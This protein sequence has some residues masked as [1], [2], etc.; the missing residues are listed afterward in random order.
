MDTATMPAPAATAYVPAT[1]ID[2]VIA[3]LEAVSGYCKKNNSRAGYF[4]ML[5][6]CVTCRVKQG[7]LNNE[8]ENGPRME[9]LD[10]L[11]ANR[12]L[13]AWH[14]WRTGGRPTASWALAFKA[15]T[16]V[17]GI[18]LQHLL[19]GINAHINLDLGVATVETMS[20]QPLDG[21]Q[22]DFNAINA[23]LAAMIGTTKAC[24]TKI[25]PLMYLLKLQKGNLDDLL[26]QFS[27]DEARK[28]AWAFAVSLSEK[29][30]TAYDECIAARDSKIA[31]L[32]NNIAYPDSG[33]LRFTV[34]IIRLFE[35]K[36]I[37]KNICSLDMR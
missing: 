13:Q 7:I 15:V 30:G 36:D 2:E 3:Q 26:V 25:N 37:E 29:T 35:H 22:K 27:I 19:L 18:V 10:V 9:R 5:Y 16:E 21:I 1:T 32:A 20:G 12:Y 11:F 24:L 17:P 8:F 28:G 14:D 23:L 4:A 33:L 34:K 31:E 6:Y